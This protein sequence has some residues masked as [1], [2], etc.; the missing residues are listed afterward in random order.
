MDTVTL[1]KVRA[2][3]IGRGDGDL[4]L[5]PHI[6]TARSEPLQPESPFSIWVLTFVRMTVRGSG[7]EI[8]PHPLNCAY[9]RRRF[10]GWEA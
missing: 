6:A 10:P 7:P 8:Y 2:Q 1:T 5:I 4:A 9:A 3:F